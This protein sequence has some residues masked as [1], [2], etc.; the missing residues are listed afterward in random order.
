M[1]A[2]IHKRD[3]EQED[4][5]FCIP[6]KA[7]KFDNTSDEKL[8]EF[9]SWCTLEGLSVSKKVTKLLYIRR[10]VVTT[11]RRRQ[12]NTASSPLAVPIGGDEG[13]LFIINVVRTPRKFSYDNVRT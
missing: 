10:G 5:N 11:I 9:L 2:S 4:D 6:S 3:L 1:A 8:S 7:V 12:T 13:C